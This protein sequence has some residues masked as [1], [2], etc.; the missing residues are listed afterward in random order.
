MILIWSFS[1]LLLFWL[2]TIL[3]T[4][5]V[6]QS[7]VCENSYSYKG[8][9]KSQ[10]MQLRFSQIGWTLIK[11][12]RPMNHKTCI[13]A[14]NS[15]DQLFFM[16]SILYLSS[17]WPRGALKFIWTPRSCDI[18]FSLCSLTNLPR[19]VYKV[20]LPVFSIFIMAKCL[21]GSLQVST[22]ISL[23]VFSVGLRLLFGVVLPPALLL[24]A[25]FS[26]HVQTLVYSSTKV[27][28]WKYQTYIA[29]VSQETPRCPIRVL[30]SSPISTINKVVG[31]LW[32]KLDSL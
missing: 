2:L 4:D 8:F 1:R 23:F 27:I 20:E 10:N 15:T 26:S 12:F 5:P 3:F 24:V 13:P 25:F 28:H 17:P 21:C 19:I 7:M 18:I 31:L 9:C 11:L 22:R 6:T 14:I 29:A 30:T 16:S 32:W